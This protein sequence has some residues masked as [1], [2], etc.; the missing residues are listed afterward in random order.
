MAFLDVEPF[1]VTVVVSAGRG[2]DSMSGWRIADDRVVALDSVPADPALTITV[3]PA[4]L[5]LLISGEL[6]PAVAYMQGRLKP[7]GDN[8]LWL[9]LAKVSASP[10]YDEWRSRQTA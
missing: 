2:A 5:P 7:A 10:S 8:E 6:S 3:T 1:E 9:A 4:D